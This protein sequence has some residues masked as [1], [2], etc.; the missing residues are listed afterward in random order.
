MNSQY[1]DAI[2][3]GMEEDEHLIIACCSYNKEIDRAYDHI[4]IKKIPQMLL[5]RWYTGRR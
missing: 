1:L 2:K 4:T 5:E 3:S